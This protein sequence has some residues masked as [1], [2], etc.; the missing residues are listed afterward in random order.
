MDKAC[1]E[2]LFWPE[3]ARCLLA[4]E[5]HAD[6]AARLAIA[7]HALLL[8]RSPDPRVQDS[9]IALV[10]ELADQA[11]ATRAAIYRDQLALSESRA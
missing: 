11:T 2:L 3:R 6:T 7:T 10:S 5:D 8:E 4:A 1:L 9:L